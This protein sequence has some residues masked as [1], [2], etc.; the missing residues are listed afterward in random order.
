MQTVSIT[1]RSISCR[2]KENASRILRTEMSPYYTAGKSLAIFF[3]NAENSNQGDLIRMGRIT[4]DLSLFEK[5]ADREE[6]VHLGSVKT[7]RAQIISGALQILQQVSRGRRLPV[8]S[9][10]VERDVQ[11]LLIRRVLDV[12]HNAVHLGRA[13]STL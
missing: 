12:H 5:I 1:P 7:R 3:G 10:F 6:I 11:H 2:R 9:G 13:F 4:S 8:A